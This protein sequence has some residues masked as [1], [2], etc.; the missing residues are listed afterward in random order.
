LKTFCH[1]LTFFGI[2]P[3]LEL[4]LSLVEVK[5]RRVPLDQAR[6]AHVSG[7]HPYFGHSFK[8]ILPNSMNDYILE[9]KKNDENGALS[10]CLEQGWRNHLENSSML[11][12]VGKIKCKTEIVFL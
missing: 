1:L 10:L 2:T 12:T 7:H 8:H 5:K 4:L 6:A 11:W 9:T 3:T